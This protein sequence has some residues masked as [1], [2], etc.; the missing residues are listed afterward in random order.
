MSVAH[1]VCNN[2][3]VFLLPSIIDKKLIVNA[4]L[5]MTAVLTRTQGRSA[6][7]GFEFEDCDSSSQMLPPTQRQ[8]HVQERLVQP[9]HQ[10]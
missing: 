9:E 4:N 5:L 7:C 10:W 2:D 8:F 1:H 6:R 3:D